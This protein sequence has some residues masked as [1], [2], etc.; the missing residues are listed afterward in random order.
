MVRDGPP[1]NIP[2][3]D[4]ESFKNFEKQKIEVKNSVKNKVLTQPLEIV[5]DDNFAL[6]PDLCT[7]TVE[8]STE[9]TKNLDNKNLSKLPN[10]NMHLITSYVSPVIDNLCVVAPIR[11]NITNDIV[12]DQPDSPLSSSSIVLIEEI[13]GDDKSELNVDKIP[14][15]FYKVF[16]K[17]K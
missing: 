10:T 3:I 2:L 17:K 4:L 12:V 14:V 7:N 13:F 5:L 16:K 11:S 6:Q 9:L 1:L 15:Y 8:S